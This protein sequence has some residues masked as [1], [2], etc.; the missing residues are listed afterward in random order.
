MTGDKDVFTGWVV[1]HGGL[2]ARIASTYERRPALIEE[3]VQDI[4]V[5]LWRAQPS[6]RGHASA[7]TFV[8]RI[9]HNVCVS[10]VRRSDKVGLAPLDDAIPDNGAGPELAIDARLTRERLVAAIHEL[11]L[12]LR[13]P[14]VL[15]L[16]GFSGAEIGQVLSIT[17]NNVGVRLARAKAALQLAFGGPQS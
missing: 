10:H 2:I 13:Q 12:S 1:D 16:E 15:Y 6:F 8:A 11:P 3:L 5:A 17:Q 7:R 14:M 4:L 9:A